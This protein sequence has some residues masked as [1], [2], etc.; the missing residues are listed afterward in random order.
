MPSIEDV[1]AGFKR[2]CSEKL[3][4]FHTVFNISLVYRYFM[5][6]PLNTKICYTTRCIECI[7]NGCSI[8]FNIKKERVWKLSEWFII[9][10]YSSLKM[11][12][13]LTLHYK[14]RRMSVFYEQPQLLCNTRKKM[15]PK[16]SLSLLCTHYNDAFFVFTSEKQV[17]VAS[18]LLIE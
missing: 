17:G 4:L 12:P 6:C 18:T 2:W 10:G 15:R 11:I 5:N 8:R 13:N 7:Q 16:F 9:Y 1:S 3:H 14:L